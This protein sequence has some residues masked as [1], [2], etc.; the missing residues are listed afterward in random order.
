MES[1]ASGFPALNARRGK[2]EKNDVE[3]VS[4]IRT[5][6]APVNQSGCPEVFDFMARVPAL[7][8]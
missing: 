3:A 1:G 6:G 7:Y 5:H 8:L 2:P 4:A